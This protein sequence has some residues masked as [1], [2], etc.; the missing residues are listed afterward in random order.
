[1]RIAFSKRRDVFRKTYKGRLDND[2]DNIEN[3]IA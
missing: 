2:K 1:M 3:L